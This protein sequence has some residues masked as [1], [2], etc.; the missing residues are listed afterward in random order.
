[1]LQLLLPLVGDYCNYHVKMCGH[2]GW[3]SDAGAGAGAGTG[4]GAEF[5]RATGGIEMGT[6]ASALT[7]E[8]PTYDTPLMSAAA[9]A[10][11]AAAGTGAGAGMA[12]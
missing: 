10:R 6:G 4:K 12:A 1:M 5:G 7:A 11:G 2:S 3:G 8:A 9:D